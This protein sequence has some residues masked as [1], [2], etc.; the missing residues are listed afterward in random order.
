MQS[1]ARS[2]VASVLVAAATLPLA[3]QSAV[4]APTHEPV[5]MRPAV[6]GGL[7]CGAGLLREFTLHI[8][9]QYQDI[10]ARLVR[11]NRV[12]AITGRMEGATLRTDPQ[13][14]HTMELLAQDN[15]LR[16]VGASGVLAMA[17]GQFF[18]RAVGGS[19]TH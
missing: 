16:I 10:E 9:Q 5:S 4:P 14:D 2:F 1:P 19:C 12:R 11:K 18:T 17:K 3:V 7:W 15:E 8:A 13:R 6:V